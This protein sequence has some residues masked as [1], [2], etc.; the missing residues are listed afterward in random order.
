MNQSP[1]PSRRDSDRDLVTRDTRTLRSLPLGAQWEFTR[2]HPYYQL[3]WRLAPTV[4]Q[5]MVRNNVTDFE[6]AAR[7]LAMC[8]AIGVVPH[9]SGLPDPAK[10][11]SELDSPG[12]EWAYPNSVRPLL[13]R[14]LVCILLRALPREDAEQAARLL[15]AV[16]ESDAIEGDDE[17]RSLM[18]NALIDVTMA[19]TGG[20]FLGIVDAPFFAVLIECSQR[21][22]EA[23]LSTHVK[24]LREQHGI[25][26]SR[27]QVVKM[28]A[29]LDAFDA[30]EG[31][32]SG[33][34]HLDQMLTVRAA[35][36]RLKSKPSTTWTR[37]CEAFRL[38]T[39]HKYTFELWFGVLAMFKVA[40]SKFSQEPENFGMLERR[41]EQNRQGRARGER[42]PIPES[43]VAGTS[44]SASELLRH[45]DATQ[46]N[47][48]LSIL[49]LSLEEAFESDAS[50]LEIAERL[51]YSEAFI[52]RCREMAR[53]AS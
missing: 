15:T 16:N 18:R 26:E 14:D 12:A 44:E 7:V 11:F 28:K 23:D 33:H 8:A 47:K 1:M 29:Y 4:K 45:I 5:E 2:R 19:M 37:Y 31:W 6:Q 49:R 38:L 20:G 21:Q 53:E 46:T 30:I 24:R 50:D 42:N 36:T 32:R 48:Q 39:G 13:V 35:S 34:F 25:T 51:G 43:V 52:T 40:Q 10:E 27:V 41:S 17:N 9:V 3:I 22:I